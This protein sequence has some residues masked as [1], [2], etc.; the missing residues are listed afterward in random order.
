MASSRVL[1]TD[2]T[3]SGKAALAGSILKLAMTVMGVGDGRELSLLLTDDEEIRGLNSRFRGK[4]RPTDVLSFPMDDDVLLGDIAV[5]MERARA[6]ADEAGETLEAE[7]ARLLVHGLL[8]L[9]GYD[10]VHGGRQAAKMREREE[11]LLAE[12]KEEGLLDIAPRG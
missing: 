11:F 9:L 2:R 10:H 1:V 7:L 8:H 5:S 3:G 6:Q 4:D 12:L